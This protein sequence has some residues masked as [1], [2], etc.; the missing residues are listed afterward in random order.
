[1][2]IPA[3]GSSVNIKAATLPSLYEEE[4]SNLSLAGIE[5]VRVASL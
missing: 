5:T 2:Y 1:V 4:P 3:V